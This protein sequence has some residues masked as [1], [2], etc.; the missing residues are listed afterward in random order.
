MK[1]EKTLKTVDPIQNR[2]KEQPQ[3]DNKRIAIP[4]G[5][6]VTAESETSI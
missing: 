2:V 6:D 5:T 3:G 1:K 4:C